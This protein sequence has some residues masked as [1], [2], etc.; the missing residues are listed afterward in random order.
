[1]HPLVCM[2]PLETSELIAFFLL[3]QIKLDDLFDAIFT[4]YDR[5]SQWYHSRCNSMK[6]PIQ[7]DIK[8]GRLFSLICCTPPIDSTI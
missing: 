8:L 7:F 2:S 6:F 5:H 3:I 4:Q 1:M